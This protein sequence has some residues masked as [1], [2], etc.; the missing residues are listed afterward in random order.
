MPALPTAASAALHLALLALAAPAQAGREDGGKG[1][2][3]TREQLEQRLE[4]ARKGVLSKMV[5]D[6]YADDPLKRKR[7]LADFQ[8]IQSEHYLLFTNGPTNTVRKFA[9]TLEELYD[10][11]K[12]EIP[13]EDID[14]LLTCYIFKD[15]EEYFGFCV[16]VA[17]WPEANARGTAGHANASYY[18]TYYQS[19]TAAV[20]F[21]EATHQIVGAC[22]KVGGVGSWFQ[23]GLAVYFE[24]KKTNEKPSAGMRAA[25]KRGDY[26]PLE[27]LFAMQSL[28][29][30]PKGNGLR[31]Y[32]H[33]GALIDF[34]INTRLEP[35]AGRFQDFLAAARRGRGFGRG[36]KVS[37]DLVRE[38]YGLSVQEL[39]DLWKRHE[40]IRVRR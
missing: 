20:V 31:S 2:E 6:R 23:E 32:A 4:E 26:Y 14:R 3:L 40:G 5:P 30:D 15:N 39:E 16:K 10:H 21:H 9:V 12:S 38:V 29:F 1:R 24:K 8:A 17:G 25:L 22:I 11:V 18:A 27:E 19:P 13:F 33:A 35:V 37:E 34:M 7:W 36:K 28:L